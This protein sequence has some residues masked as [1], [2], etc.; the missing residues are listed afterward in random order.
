MLIIVYQ[1]VARVIIAFGRTLEQVAAKEIAHQ[2]VIG[3]VA[4]VQL[5]LHK[6]LLDEPAIEAGLRVWRNIAIKIWKRGQVILVEWQRK[7]GRIEY[8]SAFYLLLLRNP[9]Q[10]IF[11]YVRCRINGVFGMGG[12]QTQVER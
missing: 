8:Q 9:A 1:L 7:Q 2:V 11:Y 10:K 6:G 5:F 3:M 4:M 12:K